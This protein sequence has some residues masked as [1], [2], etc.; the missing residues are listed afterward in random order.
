MGLEKYFKVDPIRV[1]ESLHYLYD[2]SSPGAVSIPDFLQPRFLAM[3]INDIYNHDGMLTYIHN[4]HDVKDGRIEEEFETAKL[5]DDR[6]ILDKDAF[7]VIMQL[8]EAYASFH[9]IID[10]ITPS[11]NSLN[12]HRYI[13]QYKG[14]TP[15]RDFNS[16]KDLVSI[17]CISGEADVG[18][19]DNI[20]GD[21]RQ[22]L[23]SSPG[24]LILLRAPRNDDDRK[25][26]SWR[27]YHFVENIKT[28]RYSI[29]IRQI[30]QQ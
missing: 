7:P 8:R 12:V 18:I 2:S 4:I 5:G 13:P 9:S 10:I 6:I 17:F 30:G 22:L 1:R 21:N 24:S 14:I 26:H 23:D 20:K 28:E 27:P 25:N 15:H 29:G 16:D 11:F 19:C 3:L